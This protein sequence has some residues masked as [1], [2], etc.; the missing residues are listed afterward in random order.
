MQPKRSENSDSKQLP[1][2]V[3][4]AIILCQV[5]QSGARNVADGTLALA[6]T[7]DTTKLTAIFA[8]NT[9]YSFI[10]SATTEKQRRDNSSPERLPTPRSGGKVA[11][12]RL[13]G[14][15]TILAVYRR[16]STP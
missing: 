13:V 11:I 12:I 5:A 9:L 6:T 2:A 14:D 4:L 10:V 3:T 7:S 1:Y 16:A 15:C 8:L